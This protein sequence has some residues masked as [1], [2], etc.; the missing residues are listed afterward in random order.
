MKKTL[1]FLVLLGLAFA[2]CKKSPETIGNNLI[3]DNNYIGVYHTDTTEIVCHSYFDSIA[4]SNA[5][6]ALLGGMKDPVLVL[7]KLDST[8]SSVLRWRVK[9]LA[10]TL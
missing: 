3:S 6:S 9:A 10:T 4:T 8:R 1:F 2:S 5:S 7:R